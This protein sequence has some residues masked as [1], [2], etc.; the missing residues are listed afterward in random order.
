MTTYGSLCTLSGPTSRG[1]ARGLEFEP[2]VP[3]PVSPG[4]NRLSLAPQV[5]ISSRGLQRDPARLWLLAHGLL[6]GDWKEEAPPR[7][8]ERYCSVSPHHLSKL[9]GRITT[10][11]CGNL[12]TVAP[13]HSAGIYTEN[14]GA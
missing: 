3:L 9:S 13:Y 6:S 12:R 4:S 10:F 11:H 2:A 5:K 14:Q 7:S 8:E 1:G